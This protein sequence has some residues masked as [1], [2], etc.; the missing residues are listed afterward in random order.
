MSENTL[1]FSAAELLRQNT[2]FAYAVII[3]QDG[4]TPRENGAK[5]L[6]LPDRIVGTIGGGPME[7]TVMA[8]AR[9]MLAD[10]TPMRVEEYDMSGGNPDNADLDSICGGACE[11]LIARIEPN[12]GNLAVFEAVAH[13][14]TAGIPSWLFY[15]I[16]Q[17][18]DAALP[19]LLAANVD[20]EVVG[21]PENAD[22]KLSHLLS[23]PLHAA[24]HGEKTVGQRV[25]A[26]PVGMLSVMY[27]FGGGHVSVE[28]AR[29]AA[30]LGFRVTVLDDREEF[31]NKQRFP[32]CQ[33]IVLDDFHD[34]PDLPTGKGTYILIITRGHAHDRTVLRWALERNPAPRY[35]GM[36]GSRIKRDATYESLAKEGF[37]PERMRTEVHC[38]I[39][40][41]IG[42]KTPAEIAVS[43]LAEIIQIRNR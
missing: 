3:S 1:N 23:S 32:D 10:N 35:L 36:I 13:A 5:M 38:P 9:E 16:D 21:L 19:F 31:A 29:L 7:G 14:E 24:V 18:A 15:V 40:L 11:V 4:S 26:D 25:V 42:A 8:I 12:A 22:A 17:N 27:L 30:N 39:G 41:T 28:V 37:D 43:I 34:L 20:G 33:C 6:I 2:A